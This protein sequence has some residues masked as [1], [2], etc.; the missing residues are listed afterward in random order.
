MLTWIKSIKHLDAD[1]VIE[2]N[3]LL[4]NGWRIFEILKRREITNSGFREKLMLLL[5]HAERIESQ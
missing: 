5:G 2:V 3:R 1:N 4:K